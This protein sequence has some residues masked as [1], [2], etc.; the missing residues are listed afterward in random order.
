MSERH[1]SC[2]QVIQLPQCTQAAVDGVTSLDTD[3]RGNSVAVQGRGDIAGTRGEH[4]SVWILLDE[5][6]Y[7]VNLINEGPR[8]VETL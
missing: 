1:V 2:T 7:D 6:F 4:K 5:Q 3:K 8:C